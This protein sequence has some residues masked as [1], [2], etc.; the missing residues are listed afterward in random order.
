MNVLN[1]STK[2]TIQLLGIPLTLIDKPSLLATI[3][4]VATTRQKK[5]LIL[6]GNIYSCNLAYE[7]PWLR[8]FFNRA[9]I[10]RIDGAGVRLGARLLG[11][12]SPPRMTWADFA[13]DLAALCE[14]HQ[15]TLFFL[16]AKPGIA[17]K[18]AI[19][20]Q[21]KH[22]H[23]H[24]VGIQDGYFDK[25]KNSSENIAIIQQI[26][27]AQPDI[28]LVG[29]GMPLQ[30]QWLSENWDNLNVAVTLT[31][32]AVFDY[33]SGELQ[34]APKWMTD[35]GLEWMGRLMIEPKRLWRRY[36][37]G[38]PLFLWRVLK[39]R[40]GLLKFEIQSNKD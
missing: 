16:G 35:N 2:T 15:L 12:K 19:K 8:T 4:Q 23:L 33:I 31:G 30:E 40:T 13:W 18:T 39:Q 20:L 32:G 27:T 34:R 11:Y 21:T 37:I 5:A 28:L 25:E 24:F 14:Q 26:N 7:T 17:E 3:Q 38:N 22:P 29:F 9:T 6:S 10:V 36:V 1:P